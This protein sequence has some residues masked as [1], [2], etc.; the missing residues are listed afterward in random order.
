MCE[1]IGTLDSVKNT[2]LSKPDL[3][4]L[5]PLVVIKMIVVY[6]GTTSKLLARL[7]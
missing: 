7:T 1:A 4:S 6:V 2:E 5:G 3:G